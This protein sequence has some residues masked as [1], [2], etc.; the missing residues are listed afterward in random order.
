MYCTSSVI[1]AKQKGQE[2][3]EREREMKC[4]YVHKNVSA[5]NMQF[6]RWC[7]GSREEESRRVVDEEQGA[8]CWYDSPPPNY[9]EVTESDSPPPSYQDALTKILVSG[10]F[11]DIM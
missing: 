6:P 4:M 3:S 2:R 5:N 1:V 11:Y 9:Q 7:G 8:S 10:D